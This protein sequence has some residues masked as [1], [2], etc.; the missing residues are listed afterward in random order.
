MRVLIDPIQDERDQPKLKIER[1]IA[2]GE[3]WVKVEHG[4][5]SGCGT[6]V[7]ISDLRA[8]LRAFE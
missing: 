2:A 6:V 8:A 5:G 3:V 1:G 7:A 4:D